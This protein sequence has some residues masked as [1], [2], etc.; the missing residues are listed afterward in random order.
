[1]TPAEQGEIFRTGPF[2]QGH[3]FRVASKLRTSK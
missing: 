3:T 1:M 2:Q